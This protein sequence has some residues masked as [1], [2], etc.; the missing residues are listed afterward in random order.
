MDFQDLHAI[1]PWPLPAKKLPNSSHVPYPSTHRPQRYSHLPGVLVHGCRFSDRLLSLS[2]FGTVSQA[3]FLSNRL[4]IERRGLVLSF[5]VFQSFYLTHFLRDDSPSR[6][7][8][9]GTTEFFCLIAIGIFTGP[10][11]DRGYHN[12]LVC[13]SCAIIIFAIMMLSLSTKYYQIMLTQGVCLGI[14]SG[15][16]LVPA[17]T[18]VANSFTTKRALAVSLVT[19]GSS[20]GR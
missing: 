7:S 1:I 19:A 16:I 6:I 12:A 4:L 3:D 13:V 18:L 10:L 17:L 9:I 11:H 15:M 5:G 2:T 14:G 8:W 20:I